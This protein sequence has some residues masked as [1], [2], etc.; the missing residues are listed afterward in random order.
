LSPQATA[1]LRQVLVPIHLEG[2]SVTETAKR[3]SIIERFGY[4]RR[5]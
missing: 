2:C 3:L 1:I 5:S 4:R